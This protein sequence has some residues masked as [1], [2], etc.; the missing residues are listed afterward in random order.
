MVPAVP[1]YPLYHWWINP[2]SR[3]TTNNS[4]H[5]DSVIRIRV[6]IISNTWQQRVTAVVRVSRC[7]DTRD[8]WHCAS[9]RIT[10]R[11]SAAMQAAEIRAI[12]R[13]AAPAPGRIPG[14]WLQTRPV[15]PKSKMLHDDDYIR[16]RTSNTEIGRA[17][18]G[19]GTAETSFASPISVL[20]VLF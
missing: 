2:Q 5:I 15:I 4:P 11:C 17:K 7:V 9:P 19:W 3:S 20:Q 12:R 16:N 13:W 1:C 6:C 10:T 14:Y 8:T 18:T